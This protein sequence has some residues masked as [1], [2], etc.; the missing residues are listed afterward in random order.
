MWGKESVDIV[1][2]WLSKE[3]GGGL[4]SIYS[5]NVL[6]MANCKVE[7][8]REPSMPRKFLPVQTS[9]LPPFPFIPI[10]LFPS[11]CDSPQWSMRPPQKKRD[12]GGVKEL[13]VIWQAKSKTF[14]SLS[15]WTC[16][17]F[18]CSHR[19]HVCLL[20]NGKAG[21][22]KMRGQIIIFATALCVM[23]CSVGSVRIYISLLVKWI[24]RREY[25]CV[26]DIDIWWVKAQTLMSWRR[27]RDDDDHYDRQGETGRVRTWTLLM[28]KVWSLI[29]WSTGRYGIQWTQRALLFDLRHVSTCGT[30]NTRESKKKWRGDSGEG[31]E[32]H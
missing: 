12:G 18:W 21:K 3:E 28:S 29:N 10:P 4:R 16:C 25:D 14:P 15:R 23:R 19:F 1:C 31:E 9:S 32:E 24:S 17:D 6:D 26:C 8:W 27:T 20:Y 2:L 30:E 7:K 13:I 22:R 5:P 11:L